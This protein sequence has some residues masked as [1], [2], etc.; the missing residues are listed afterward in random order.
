MHA[1]VPFRADHVGS[2]L[3]PASL[4][5]ARAK[6]QRGELSADAV[7]EIQRTAI[8]EVVAK[9]ESIGLQAI[10]DGEFSRDWWH[11]DFL[12]GFDGVET[13]YGPASSA[14]GGVSEQPALLKVTGKIRRTK[15]IFVDHFK[16]LKSVTKRTP[17]MTIPAPAMLHHRAGRAAVSMEAYPDINEMWVDIS[18]G[19]AEEIAELSAAGCTYLQIDDT[20]HAML[21]DPKFRKGIRNRGDD[22]DKLVHTYGDAINRA[23]ADRPAGLSVTMHT[24]RGN[25]MSAWVASGGYEP[26]AEAVFNSINVDAFFLEFDSDRAGGFEPLRFVPRTKKIVLGLVTTKTPDLESKDTLKRRIDE[27]AK[28]VPLE[29]L[30][31]SPQCGFSSTHHGNKIN[32]A[33]QWKKLELVVD[34]AREVWG[35]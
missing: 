2:L 18:R 25:F 3:R 14:F 12:A 15:P 23:L 5:E 26:V 13:Y 24:C 20:S 9:Q 27:A 1:A 17:K 19:Y 29:N 10:T 22:P 31:L 33:I 35:R 21:C 32:P 34:V 11:V 6:A 7:R 8:S 16:F 4:R 30:C 28:Y